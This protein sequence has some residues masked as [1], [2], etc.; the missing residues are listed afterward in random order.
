MDAGTVTLTLE[1]KQPGS[2]H[3]ASNLQRQGSCH[4]KSPAY[5]TCFLRELSHA[6]G[7]SCRIGFSRNSQD[8]DP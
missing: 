2:D 1:D 4:L 7:L 3:P 8:N 6:E 5:A